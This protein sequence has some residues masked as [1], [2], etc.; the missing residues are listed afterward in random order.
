MADLTKPRV[1]FC[2]V[3]PRYAEVISTAYSKCFE[4]PWSTKDVYGLLRSQTVF[5]LIAHM[6]NDNSK[7]PEV[8][9]TTVADIKRSDFIGFVLYSLASDQCEI[10]TICVIP[11][12]RR[13]G[14]AKNLMQNVIKRVKNIG[15]KEIFLEVA[16]NNEA[17]RTL[18]V[19]EGFKVFGKRDRYYRQREGRVDALQL[20]KVL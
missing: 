9:T 8:L 18:Y 14:F 1:D 20:S 19:K 4:N 2:E 13:E 5:G 7:R 6:V 16:E 15:I 3:L 12:W 10:L 17:A 11:E